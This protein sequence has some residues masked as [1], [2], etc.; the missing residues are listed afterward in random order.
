MKRVLRAGSTLIEVL[1]VAVITMLIAGMLGTTFSGMNQVWSMIT[2][3]NPA[4][5]DHRAAIDM[6]SEHI[7]N[8][9]GCRVAANGVLNSVL[10]S[11]TATEIE[12]YTDKDSCD[13]VRYF[14]SGGNLMREADGVQTKV[15]SNVTNLQFTYLTSTTYHSAWTPTMSAS[16][17][18][19]GELKNLSGVRMQLTTSVNDQ[20]V[21]SNVTIRLRNSPRKSR[22]DG[23]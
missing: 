17:P 1:I 23:L 22:L 21:T 20:S 14:L 19:M 16:T 2:G 6:L 9:Q 12:Y 3:Y 8:A 15:A 4:L 11:G 13:T 7:R 18:S 5:A 10:D